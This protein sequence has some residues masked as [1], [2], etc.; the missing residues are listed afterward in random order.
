MKNKESSGNLSTNY[1]FEIT[2][3]SPLEEVT[4]V[5]FKELKVKVEAAKKHAKVSNKTDL[6]KKIFNYYWDMEEL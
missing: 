3:K 6:G 1:D 2:E 4:T 5:S